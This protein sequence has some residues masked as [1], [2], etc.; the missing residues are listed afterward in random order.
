MVNK[1]TGVNLD[2]PAKMVS[3]VALELLAKMVLMVPPV[4]QDK[5]V[6]QVIFIIF[7]D[8]LQLI[9]RL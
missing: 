8:L 7:Y 6:N 1:D 2:F 4:F 9:L 3:Q 5:S